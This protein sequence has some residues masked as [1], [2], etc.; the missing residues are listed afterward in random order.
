MFIRTKPPVDSQ[1]HGQSYLAIMDGY[2]SS[3]ADLP[4]DASK[5]QLAHPAGLT[6]L[7]P[8]PKLRNVPIADWF[9]QER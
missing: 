5:D 7:A 8:D 4:W 6:P 1:P 2:S 3:I 9:P